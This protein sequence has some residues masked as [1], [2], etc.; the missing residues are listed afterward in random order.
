[1]KGPSAPAK[2]F[3]SFAE[4]DA[5]LLRQLERHLAPLEH[6]GLIT[7]WHKRQVTPG[8]DWKVEVDRYLNTASLILLLISPNFLASNYQY[9]VELRQAMQRH[10]SNEAQVIPIVLRPCDLI[11]TPF[12]SLQVLPR[13]HLA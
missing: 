11:G 6:E 10:A 7:V 8:I 12:E 1:M 4:E 2:I 5:S 13:N 3:C 9:G